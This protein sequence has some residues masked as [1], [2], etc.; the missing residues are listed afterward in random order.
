MA[1]EENENNEPAKLT[2]ELRAEITEEES[3]KNNV[4]VLEPGGPIIEPEDEERFE[5]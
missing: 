4:R 1:F 3:I 2:E 5:S